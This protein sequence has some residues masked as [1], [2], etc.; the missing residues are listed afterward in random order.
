MGRLMAVYYHNEDR[1]RNAELK[2]KCKKVIE[3]RIE[4]MFEAARV[5][6]ALRDRMDELM[7][8]GDDAM[9]SSSRDAVWTA[10]HRVKDNHDFLS[11]REINDT[12]LGNASSGM[13]GEYIEKFGLP[14]KV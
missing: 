5:L 8:D 6:S 9:Y 7:L 1:R 10:A 11:R 2:E 3:A 14:D 13:L 4:L 12:Y